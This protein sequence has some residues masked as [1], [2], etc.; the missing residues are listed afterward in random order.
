[1]CTICWLWGWGGDCWQQQAEEAHK[2][3]IVYGRAARSIDLRGW[4]QEE[5]GTGA[6]LS[7]E[8]AATMC[9]IGDAATK[10][11]GKEALFFLGIIFKVQTY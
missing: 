2:Y 3:V 4:G 7:N 8:N 1:M 10:T 9:T 11:K 6:A 5:E